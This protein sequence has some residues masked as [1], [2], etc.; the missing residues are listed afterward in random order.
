MY[1]L[2]SHVLAYVP[3]SVVKY[4][5][6]QPYPK[7]K[8]DKWIAALLEY[9]VEINPTKLIK[10][11]GLAQM[12]TQSNFELLG[13]NFIVGLS[14]DI[15]EEDPLQVSRKFLDSSWYSYIIY[16]LQNFQAPPELSKTKS[17]FLKKK[18]INFCML[19]DSLYWK[20]LGRVLLKC[21]IEVE[22][23]Q[24]MK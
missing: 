8:R 20:G 18:T 12:M 11:Q 2:H 23:E 10:G 7:G 4:I 22:A 6:T 1:V 5:L 21:L 16:V 15:E 24:T 14:Q 3:N 19:N 13:V 9:D 17:N